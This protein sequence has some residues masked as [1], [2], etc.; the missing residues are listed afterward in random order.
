MED[1]RIVWLYHQRREQAIAESEKK[2]GGLCHSIALNVLS[3]QEDAQ[4]CVNDTW[5]A[6]WNAMPPAFPRSLGAF[7]GRITRNL[8]ISRWRQTHTQKRYAG[9][10]V[11]LSE[12]DDCVPS[13]ENVER[14]L[15]GREL[16]ESISRWLEG[17]SP[18]DRDLFLQRYWYA[19]PVKDLARDRGEQP[20]TLSQRLSRLR[21]ELKE[22]L[23][24]KGVA[25]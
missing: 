2:Y 14:E 11:L 5:H 24:T 8:S 23:E 16:G 20:N 19:L 21:K 12:L 6:A 9:M 15:E 4:E 25:L 3:V 13:S 7:L 10:E 22:Y 17:L 18:R 1:S